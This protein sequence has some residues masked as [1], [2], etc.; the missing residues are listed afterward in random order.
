[1]RHIQHGLQMR[2]ALLRDVV[3]M[4]R[5]VP[6]GQLLKRLRILFDKRLLMTSSN[7]FTLL[8]IFRP[9]LDQRAWETPS[10]FP[11][12][13]GRFCQSATASPVVHPRCHQMVATSHGYFPALGDRSSS[14]SRTTRLSP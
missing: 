14:K 3:R 4:R 12:L 10:V 11:R 9:R 6:V 13:Q 1:L 7:V 5:D 8:R 2:Q